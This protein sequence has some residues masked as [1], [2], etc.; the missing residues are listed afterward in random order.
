MLKICQNT[1][2]QWRESAAPWPHA[3]QSACCRSSCR[4]RRCSRCRCR[5]A[6]ALRSAGPAAWS[7][8][9]SSRRRWDPQRWSPSLMCTDHGVLGYRRTAAAVTCW[10]R[11][12]H[13]AGCSPL[14]GSC[15]GRSD[16]SPYVCR[17][18]AAVRCPEKKERE[19]NIN[20]SRKH[21]Y[22]FKY[23]HLSPFSLIYL[24]T[25][26]FLFQFLISTFCLVDILRGEQVQLL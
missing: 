6:P 3:A 4:T 13:R 5:W 16:W 23:L 17:Q 10:C 2:W 22:W 25:F 26:S 19:I 14:R 8:G 9:P 18:T 1:P 20:E 15:R 7:L 24:I 11:G 21:H 12:L